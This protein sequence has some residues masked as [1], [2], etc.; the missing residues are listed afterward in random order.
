VDSMQLIE[1]QLGRLNKNSLCSYFS[2]Y[3][4]KEIRK[5]DYSKFTVEKVLL[6]SP[7]MVKIDT[8]NGENRRMR[9]I[10]VA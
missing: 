4:K 10:S 9:I 6:S 1:L 7:S 3:R 8:I 2:I 5:F